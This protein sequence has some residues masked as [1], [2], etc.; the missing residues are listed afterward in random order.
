M[1]KPKILVTSAAG[2]TGAPTV[3]E[4]LAKGYPVR[5]FVRRQDARSDALKGA[6]AEIFVGDLFDFRD[7]R[8][9]L[10]GIHRAYHC[11]PFADNVLHGAMLFALAAE[12]AK[13]EVVAMMSAWNPHATHP[14][15][16][17]RELWM[18]QNVVRWMPTV[19]VIHINPGFFAFPY[20]FGLPAVVHFGM[21]VLPLG[22][23]L[24]AP[25]SNEDIAALVANVLAEPGP[26]I[27]KRYRPTGPELLSPHNAAEIMGRVL[28]R[29]VRYRDVPTRW[30]TKYAAARGFDS[31]SIAQFRHFAEELRDGTYAIGAPTDHVE[32]VCGR[33]AEGFETIARR[34]FKHPEQ[35]WPGFNQ[36][37][38]FGTMSSFV[39]AVLTKAPSLD[40]FEAARGRPCL[41]NAQLAHESDEWLATAKRQE[42]NLL[43]LAQR[44]ESVLTDVA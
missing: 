40:A 16:F 35:V 13:L 2:H 29:R 9:A 30:F 31:W 36:G 42:L 41:V 33:P 3:R 7:L 17:T 27:G 10:N 11:P 19:E 34:Y 37:S 26:H 21:L 8:T 24:N 14:A 39:K 23:G 6:G 43:P 38:M 18:A 28:G 15:N 32:Q 22:S 44:R 25:P 5:A 12:E 4:L 1:S 20:F